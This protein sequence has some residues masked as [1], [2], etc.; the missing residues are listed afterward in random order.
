MTDW[1]PDQFKFDRDS[2]SGIARLFPVPKLVVFPHVMQPL[3]VFE[4]R[5]REMLEDAI[6]GDGLIAMALL[7]TGWEIEY[8]SRPKLV[9]WACLGKVVTHT[10]LADGR[11]NLLLVGLSRVRI[12]EELAPVR[13][14]RQARVQLADD[15]EPAPNPAT[16]H[17]AARLLDK[18]LGQMARSQGNTE[19]S[20]ALSQLLNSGMPLSMLTDLI[21]YVLP[22]P[23]ELKQSLLME[24]CVATRAE[25]LLTAIPDKVKPS[26]D[27]DSD[28]FPPPFSV[29]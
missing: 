29:N 28:A 8:A 21:G 10:R 16:E 22:L 11:Y 5:Y 2:F 13:S 4:E 26:P 15:L 23:G 25:M 14:F 18:F 12:V 3:H 6:A 17:L 1:N 7:A 20:G 19:A 27:K 9:P 24:T